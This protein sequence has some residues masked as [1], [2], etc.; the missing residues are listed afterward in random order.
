MD[1]MGI[2]RQLV[3][4]RFNEFEPVRRDFRLLLPD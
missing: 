1:Q 3:F 4:P 2:S